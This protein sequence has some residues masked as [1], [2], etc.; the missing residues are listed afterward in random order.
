[1]LFYSMTVFSIS[2][3]C[4]FKKDFSLRVKFVGMRVKYTAK[5]GMQIVGMIF[6]TR[7]GRGD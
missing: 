6:Q 1:M 3:E 5:W 7:S 2:Q 4:I